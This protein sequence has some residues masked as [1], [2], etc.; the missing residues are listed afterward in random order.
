MVDAIIG[1]IRELIQS[2]FVVTVTNSLP[3]QNIFKLDDE[4]KFFITIYKLLKM[5]KIRQFGIFS[6]I[7]D[8]NMIQKMINFYS[9]LLLDGSIH[10]SKYRIERVL[11]IDGILSIY[12]FEINNKI[13]CKCSIRIVFKGIL[14]G[15][16]TI[17]ATIIREVTLTDY[18]ILINDSIYIAE[19]RIDKSISHF[20]KHEDI[21]EYDIG[22]VNSINDDSIYTQLHIYFENY[23]KNKKYVDEYLL[24]DEHNSCTIPST[25]YG[26]II[27]M[28][29]YVENLLTIQVIDINDT[30]GIRPIKYSINDIE[31]VLH[32]LIDNKDMLG[33]SEEGLSGILKRDLV[34]VLVLNLQFLIHKNCSM[35]VKIL[36]LKMMTNLANLACD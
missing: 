19:G 29:D 9:T 17:N 5:S 14:L 6:P 26:S 34:L 25:I 28:V 13:H 36:Q 30:L 4:D 23:N 7:Y 35:I 8:I 20:V 2:R 11:D 16:Y 21:S 18:G 31:I 32:L 15:K 33:I 22:Y 24:V 1:D 10:V 27:I 12:L 3:S